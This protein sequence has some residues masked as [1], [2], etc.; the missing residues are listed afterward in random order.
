MI[1]EKEEPA[2]SSEGSE[3]KEPTN[4]YEEI[5]NMLTKKLEQYE[6]PNEENKVGTQV[7]SE[8]EGNDTETKKQEPAK[9]FR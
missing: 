8:I 2:A 7:K 3:Q 6:R 9:R 4:L 5:I 1:S